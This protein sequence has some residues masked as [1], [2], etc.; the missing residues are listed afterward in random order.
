MGPP[1]RAPLGYFELAQWKEEKS[2][3]YGT[4]KIPFKDYSNYLKTLL[5]LVWKKMKFDCNSERNIPVSFL[6]HMKISEAGY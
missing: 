6:K 5:I 1:P 2:K 4:I 3:E